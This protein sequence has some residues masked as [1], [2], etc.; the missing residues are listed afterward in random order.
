MTHFLGDAVARGRARILRLHR[1]RFAEM[2]QVA[3]ALGPRL[4][5]IMSDRVREVTRTSEQREK[6]VALGKLSAGLSH[7]LNNPASAV[8]R[9]AAALDER[10]TDLPALVERLAT[11]GLSPDDLA[12]VAS[13]TD[14][15]TMRP[16]TLLSPLERSHREDALA[17]GLDGRGVAE[18]WVLAETLVDAG[19]EVDAL[20]TLGAARGDGDGARLE[21]LLRWTEWLLGVRRLAD[22]VGT[23]AQRISQLVGAVK[24]YSH[25]DRAPDRQPTDVREG[26]DSTLVMLQHRLKQKGVRLE[27]E[28]A[29]D[30][31]LVPA[32]P[33]ELNQV[34]TNLIDNA[35]DAM[36]REG[37]LRIEARREGHSVVVRIIDSG[38]GIPPEVVPR[39]FEPF[40]TTKDVGDGTGLG[41]DVVQRIVRQ[42]GGTIDVQSRPGRTEFRVRL[43]VDEERDRRSEK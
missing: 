39:I 30:L 4:V 43:A 8:R 12:S 20:A 2:L 32:W 17:T 31:P 5:G 15:S 36:D 38:H 3:P 29:P 42:H 7:E 25:M 35:I 16:P 33:G 28:L 10:L 34:W 18:S 27:R 14:P 41:L 1:D 40:F 26:I 24:A 22:E 19:L 6:M 11:R 9:G 21:V 13:I 23:A 37:T